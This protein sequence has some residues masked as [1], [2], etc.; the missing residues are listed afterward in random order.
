MTTINDT[1][2]Q[3]MNTAGLSGYTQHVAPVV[4]A[5]VDREQRIVGSIIEV[6]QQSDL[7]VS[8]VR[9]TLANAGLHMPAEP[10]AQQPLDAVGVNVP[11]GTEGDLARVLARIDQTLNGL[12]GFARN[13]GYNG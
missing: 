2:N 8:A 4:T 11:A 12:V 3:A 10:V 13:H 9:Q 6:A 5:L 1:V 7:D